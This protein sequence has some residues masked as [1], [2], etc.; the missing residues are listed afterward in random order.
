MKEVRV[1]CVCP[2]NGEYQKSS[3]FDI[4]FRES[5]NAIFEIENFK[6]AP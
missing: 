6:I 1:E 5:E 2:C 3:M 4:H